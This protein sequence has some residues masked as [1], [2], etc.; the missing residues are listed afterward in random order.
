MTVQ[1]NTNV[2][3]FLGNGAAT[4]PIGFKFNSAADLVVQ[5]TVIATGVTTTLTLNSDYSV[6]GASVEEGGSI[7]F[8]Q[9]PTSAESI[10]VTRV[11]DL[12]QLTDL[13]NQG[14][15]YAEVHEAVF[16][17]LVMIDQ[18]QQTEIDDANARSDEAVATANAA[19]AKSDQAV[20]KAAQNL[21]DMQA[22]YDAFEQ[23]ASL[24]IIGDYAPGLVVD[25]YNKI[26]RK[27]GEFYRAKA[28]LTL[29]YQLT[30]DW[31]TDSAYLV[32]V[33]D[34][35]LRQDLTTADG[36]DMVGY[37]GRTVADKLGDVANIMDY[38][39]VADG[40]TDDAPA[41]RAAMAA[42][43]AKGGGY[44][45]LP[46][47]TYYL[48][49][50]DPRGMAMLPITG[51]NEFYT[52]CEIGD[53]V[54]V[55]GDGDATVIKYESN[56]VGE[57][58]SP[59]SVDGIYRGDVGALFANFRVRANNNTPYAVGSF[60]VRDFR[61]LYTPLLNQTKD[62][63]DGQVVRIYSNSGEVA[64]GNFTVKNV[65][66]TSNPGHQCFSYEKVDSFDASDNRIYSPGY[67]SNPSNSDHSVFFIT[68]TKARYA[69]N[70]CFGA[71]PD[72]NST[73]FESHCL[74]NDITGNLCF[75][76]NVFANAVSQVVHPGAA[77]DFSQFRIAHNYARQCKTFVMDF[78]YTANRKSSL[79]ILN[80]NILLLAATVNDPEAIVRFANDTGSPPAD[81]LPTDLIIIRGNTVDFVES[82][83]LEVAYA[84]SF[85]ALI[86]HS[87][88]SHLVVENNEVRKARRAVVNIEGTKIVS[89][90]IANNRLLNA[91]H[92]GNGTADESGRA[93][94][95]AIMCTLSP[96]SILDRLEVERNTI[97]NAYSGASVAYALLV[98]N[99]FGASAATKFVVKWNTVLGGTTRNVFVDAQGANTHAADTF[100]IDHTHTVFDAASSYAE[101][102]SCGAPLTAI[103][104]GSVGRHL[105]VTALMVGSGGSKSPK[106]EAHGS[107]APVARYWFVGNVMHNTAPAPSGAM[108]WVCTVAGTPGTWKAFGTIA[109]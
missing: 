62:Y 106:V 25:G 19:N 14:K 45:Y 28:E 67:S 33:G 51:K 88:V 36:A 79:E 23:G 103:K 15:F 94:R 55:Y 70:Q 54:T 99:F 97:S 71:V 30:G 58:L 80:N 16:D 9:A 21:I 42:L 77:Y 104:A 74:Y 24:V 46:A 105:D 53:G 10:K 73:F 96:G 18:Q 83:G 66:V 93:S 68:G 7:T 101:L 4:Y 57:Y 50:G 43:V 109:A 95:A 65:N 5:K 48:N 47:G 6:A 61:V 52:V 90:R 34:A 75:G 76:M 63:I 89:A 27:D 3:S 108:G 38:G 85:D 72:K 100:E 29:P 8:S 35:V 17:K 87:Q 39:A 84:T 82:T 20:A 69:G 86:N 37:K 2:A 13:R 11:V 98:A 81:I 107:A 56:R 40:V 12:L 31:A 41:L 59:N 60:H 26:F 1:T 32:G 92:R 44:L 49:S 22:Q 91:C 102:V 78:C 64:N